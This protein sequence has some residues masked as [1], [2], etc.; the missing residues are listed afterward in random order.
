MASEKLKN[1]FDE[2]AIDGTL[3][4]LNDWNNLGSLLIRYRHLSAQDFERLDKYRPSFPATFQSVLATISQ[5]VND[6][7]TG[8]LLE[9]CLRLDTRL[10]ESRS[11]IDDWKISSFSEVDLA[12]LLSRFSS[13][14]V[15][16]EK[17]EELLI[18]SLNK[19]SSYSEDIQRVIYDK[20][21]DLSTAI[22]TAH[23]FQYEE[24]ERVEKKWHDMR[25]RAVQYRNKP[26]K[27]LKQ[28]E[29][30]VI[31]QIGFCAKRDFAVEVWKIPRDIMD[32]SYLG[33]L[34]NKISALKQLVFSKYYHNYLGFDDISE[35]EH[36]LYFFE[37]IKGTSLATIMHG[38]SLINSPNLLHYWSREI[39]NGLSDLLSMCTHRITTKFSLENVFVTDQ[40]MKLFF[41]NLSFGDERDEMSHYE[42]EAWILTIYGYI[43]STLVLGNDESA[44]ISTSSINS[45]LKCIIE[46]SLNAYSRYNEKQA[47]MKAN[48]VT[49][50]PTESPFEEI[51]QELKIVK[52]SKQSPNKRKRLQLKKLD[53]DE[54]LKDLL[55]IRRLQTHPYFN[56]ST[57]SVSEQIDV[58]LNEFEYLSR[59]V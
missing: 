32:A 19:L 59:S 2:I 28:H 38:K 30:G 9:I 33:E 5:A 7:D 26:I 58:L 56:I 53:K 3:D 16:L 23:A 44:S 48:S 21:Y 52:E 36:N 18:H 14:S 29:N 47:Q 25:V 4:S 55:T 13:L 54:Y 22:K 34:Y 1:C 27:V 31:K 15:Q 12:A 8:N 6:S 17:S 45:E 49:L 10:Q 57:E 24:L 42:M 46:E 41:K 50:S 51:E 37:L 11:M 43:L 20:V 40:C 39:L 35:S